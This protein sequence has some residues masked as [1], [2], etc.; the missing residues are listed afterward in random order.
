[1]SL[2][3]HRAPS[4]F[5]APGAAG[6]ASAR[7]HLRLSVS[8][9]ALAA[10][11][12]A[13]SAETVLQVRANASAGTV[14]NPIDAT[15]ISS[16]AHAPLSAAAFN[17]ITNGQGQ[18]TGAAS[19]ELG[20]GLL[21]TRND[22]SAAA[23]ADPDFSGAGTALGRTQMSWSDRLTVSGS[24]AG[25]GILNAS[26][27][28]VAVGDNTALASGTGLSQAEFGAGADL[29]VFST[30]TEPVRVFTAST[31]QRV[32]IDPLAINTVNGHAVGSILGAWDVAIPFVFGQAFDLR[33]GLSG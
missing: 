25:A 28:L 3:A 19:G 23:S 16:P 7:R 29:V 30:P 9:L 31:S 32:G 24:Y 26:V 13:S 17:T 8:A 14:I 15:S 12:L 20:L 10:L 33:A 22:A 21:T 2:S 27:W 1:M 5:L 18:G 11:P 6:R 4:M